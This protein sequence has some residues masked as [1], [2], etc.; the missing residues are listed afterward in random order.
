MSLRIQT[1]F[2]LPFENKYSLQNIEPKGSK[3]ATE[4]EPVE[5]PEPQLGTYR[6]PLGPTNEMSGECAL[7][8]P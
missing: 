4:N 8:W 3:A 7:V 1:E 2:S 5:V 6:G